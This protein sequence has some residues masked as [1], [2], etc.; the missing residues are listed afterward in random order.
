MFSRDLAKSFGSFAFCQ[1]LTDNF[2][3][4]MDVN[5]AGFGDSYT[6][7]KRLDYTYGCYGRRDAFVKNK[8]NSILAFR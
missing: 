8:I 3:G 2:V 7:E 1:L 5:H 6:T 4:T